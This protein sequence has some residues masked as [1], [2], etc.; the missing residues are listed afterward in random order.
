MN[1]IIGWTFIL[2]SPFMGGPLLVGLLMKHLYG[3]SFEIVSGSIMVVWV[4]LF[5]L[6]FDGSKYQKGLL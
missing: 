6:W 5:C 4:L 3:Y 2:M 1:K